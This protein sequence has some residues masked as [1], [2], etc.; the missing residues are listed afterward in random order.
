V[1]SLATWG[2]VRR[3]ECPADGRHL[4]A[5]AELLESQTFTQ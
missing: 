3:F 1:A 4:E 5:C 2:E